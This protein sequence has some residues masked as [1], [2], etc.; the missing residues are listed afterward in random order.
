MQIYFTPKKK[1]ERDAGSSIVSWFI[2]ED[3][4]GNQA[5]FQMWASLT[6]FFDSWR[7]FLGDYTTR[8]TVLPLK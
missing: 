3:K 6:L 2:Q 7:L 4:L 8:H 5:G 1:K